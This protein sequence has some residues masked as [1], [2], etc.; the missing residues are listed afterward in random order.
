MEIRYAQA[1]ARRRLE[2]AARRVHADGRRREGVFRRE[3]QR[4]PVLAVLVRCLW[5]AGEDV[6]PFED[7]R[8]GRV[9]GY[10]G[11]RVAGDGEVFLGQAFGGGLGCHVSTNYEVRSAL[12]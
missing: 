1:Q 5:R 4:A 7:V 3:G 11:G 8:V 6:V 10:V 2:A 9:R 12:Y